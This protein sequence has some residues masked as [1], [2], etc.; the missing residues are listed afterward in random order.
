MAMSYVALPSLPREATA[1]IRIRSITGASRTPEQQVDRT[2]VVKLAERLTSGLARA[3]CKTCILYAEW[4]R[5]TARQA[6]T[7]HRM[8]SP[9]ASD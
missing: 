6:C 9:R 7:A 2:D 1:A 3:C 5:A 8:G 4:T